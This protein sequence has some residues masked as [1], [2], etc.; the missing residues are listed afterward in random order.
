MRSSV[1]TI[2]SD[3]NKVLQSC[4]RSKQVYVTPTRKEMTVARRGNTK[5]VAFKGCSSIG[6]FIN[7]IDIRNCKIHGDRVGIHKGFCDKYKVLYDVIKKEVVNLDGDVDN[8]VFTGH[9]AGGSVAQIASLFLCDE[10]KSNG[11]E[12]SCFTFG[13]PKTGDES[14][15]DALECSLGDRLLRV[16]TYEDLVCLLPVQ[17][18][19][20]HAGE[21]LILGTQANDF[22]ECYYTD[23]VDMIGKMRALG[24]L[25]KNELNSM[26]RAHSCE[27]YIWNMVRYNTNGGE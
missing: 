14:F 1:V 7:S 26:I 12:T 15:K 13:T 21:A 10:L 11:I 17:P 27:S 3:Y 19:F 20:V 22:F 23:Y 18:T 4:I 16:E 5:Y 9:S 2:K 8:V 24:L 6:D 25:K